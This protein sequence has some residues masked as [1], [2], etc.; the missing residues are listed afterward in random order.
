MLRD[1]WTRVGL[2][3]WR[4]RKRYYTM[5]RLEK[6][7]LGLEERREATQERKGAPPRAYESALR[8]L[9]FRIRKPRVVERSCFSLQPKGDP[10]WEREPWKGLSKR[11]AASLEKQVPSLYSEPA[12]SGPVSAAEDARHRV[13]QVEDVVDRNRLQG[14][15]LRRGRTEIE[16]N[17]GAAC[18]LSRFEI[19]P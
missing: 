1:P 11:K 7:L 12:G 9:V 14:F 13:W 3:F 17:A 16:Q 8:S 15:S 10:D 2:I 5:K 4:Q 18:R 6:R 19:T